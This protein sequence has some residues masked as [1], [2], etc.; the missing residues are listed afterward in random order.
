M[1]WW[2]RTAHSAHL[3]LGGVEPVE[4]GRFDG[5]SILEIWTCG[6]GNVGPYQGHDLSQKVCLFS[7]GI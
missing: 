4:D 5:T 6:P 7:N 2:P 1:A 3:N